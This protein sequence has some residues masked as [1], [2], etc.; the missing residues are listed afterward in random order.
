MTEIRTFLGYNTS[1]KAFIKFYQLDIVST[2]SPDQGFGG[3]PL[4]KHSLFPIKI[5]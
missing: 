5:H 3:L 1:K 2:E 4:I